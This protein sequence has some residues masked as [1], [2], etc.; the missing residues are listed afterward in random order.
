MF[1]LWIYLWSYPP[2]MN[3]AQRLAII[4]AQE[5]DPDTALL[6]A[7]DRKS[8]LAVLRGV[9]P[10]AKAHTRKA[11]T[12]YL[13][14][15]ARG[16]RHRIAIKRSGA[17]W[18][19]MQAYKAASGAFMAIV[20]AAQKEGRAIMQALR[21]ETLDKRAMKGWLEPVYYKGEKV[22][23]IRKFSDKCLELAVKGHD[24][25]GEFKDRP[26]KQGSGQTIIFNIHNMPARG[27][28]PLPE[29]KGR[30]IDITADM[31]EEIA[32][33]TQPE[34]PEGVNTEGKSQ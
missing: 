9:I 25:T 22:G 11:I 4:D 26:D 20:E 24:K 28:T 18:A 12:E 5:L 7:E 27:S 23:V 16:V 1:S 33:T 30:T 3:K 34:Q 31:R 29:H 19:T 13:Q 21:L 14:L 8:M 15:I 6:L 17:P 2:L 32:T 10:Q